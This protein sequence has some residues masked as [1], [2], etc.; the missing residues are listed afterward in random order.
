MAV[1]Q[2]D[3]SPRELDA[4]LAERLFGKKHD[5]WDCYLD[6]YSTTGDGM[7]LV[8]DAMQERPRVSNID[9]AWDRGND[10]QWGVTFWDSQVTRSLGCAVSKTL[11]RA[12][13]L[14]A[15][16]ALAAL[17]MEAGEDEFGLCDEVSPS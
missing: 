14:A 2:T 6:D 16:A 10:G 9:I 12:V 17:E 13:A 8:L 4:A 11:P 1:E 15:L 5:G 7:L 3:L